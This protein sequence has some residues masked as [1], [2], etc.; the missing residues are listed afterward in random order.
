MPAGSTA[1]NFDLQSYKQAALVWWQGIVEARVGLGT[2]E[3]YNALSPMPVSRQATVPETCR[4]AITPQGSAFITIYRSSADLSLRRRVASG[5]CL[6]LSFREIDSR[7]PCD[8]RWHA[9]ARPV[10]GLLLERPA[11]FLG[12]TSIEKTTRFL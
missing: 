1:M 3:I 2:D 6:T 8:V 9:Y 7:P 4:D 11:P 10:R 5:I 12:T